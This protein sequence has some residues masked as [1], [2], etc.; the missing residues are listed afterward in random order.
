MSPFDSQSEDQKLEI[1]SFKAALNI[2]LRKGVIRSVTQVSEEKCR[3]TD[4]FYILS[5]ANDK[6]IARIPIGDLAIEKERVKRKKTSPVS[7]QGNSMPST[8][9]CPDCGNQVSSIAKSC[10]KCGRP[11]RRKS[12]VDKSSAALMIFG[13]VLA[14]LF[15]FII[16]G[17]TLFA[18]CL[19]SLL[20]AIIASSKGESFLKWYCYGIIFWILAIIHS[21][22]I[23]G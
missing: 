5:D 2:S 3:Q 13:A 17:P 6:A 21:I 10:P 22:I 11:F 12:A 1:S 9:P 8:I 7:Q 14:G 19:L 18:L 23:S 15:L 4:N 16:S 20:P